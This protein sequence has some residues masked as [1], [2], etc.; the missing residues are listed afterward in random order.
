MK[1]IPAIIRNM[2]VGY[3]CKKC[4]DQAFRREFWIC[5]CAPRDP[6]DVEPLRFEDANIVLRI[7]SLIGGIL[8]LLAIATVLNTILLGFSWK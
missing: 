2:K 6:E 5:R 3:R 4:G 7:I 1:Q 8:L